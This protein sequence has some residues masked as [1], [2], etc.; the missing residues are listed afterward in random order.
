MALV[1]VETEAF[2]TVEGIASGEWDRFLPKI[3]IAVRDRQR[4]LENHEKIP[5][6][7]RSMIV[8]GHQVW[9]WMQGPGKPH[10]EIR[11]TGLVL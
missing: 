8:S 4:V 7:T 5:P 3:L 1:S 10:W 11:G 6:K 9:V 2:G